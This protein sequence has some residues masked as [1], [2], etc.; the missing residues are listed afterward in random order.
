MHASAAH[1]HEVAD[2]SLVLRLD[3]RGKEACSRKQH[4]FCDNVSFDL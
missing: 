1:M 4:H 3:L 2:R